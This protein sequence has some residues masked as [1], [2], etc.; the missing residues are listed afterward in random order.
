MLTEY[1]IAECIVDSSL[2]SVSQIARKM[3]H[4]TCFFPQEPQAATSG[5]A[6]ED[7]PR[8]SLC[9]VQSAPPKPAA[10][11]SGP[12]GTEKCTGKV[13]FLP[14]SLLLHQRLILF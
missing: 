9:S 5:L 6:G 3:R 14:C 7:V 4:H 11:V 8:T 2:F 12:L 10:L 13:I 1:S